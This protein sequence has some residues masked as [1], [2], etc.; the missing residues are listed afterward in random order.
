MYSGNFTFCPLLSVIMVGK[1][2]KS[3]GL[4]TLIH[5]TFGEV[6][7]KFLFPDFYCKK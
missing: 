5:Y 3:V 2:L 6:E 1:A 7:H 4:F